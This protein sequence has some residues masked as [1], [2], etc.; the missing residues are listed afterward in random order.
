[1]GSVISFASG[2][3]GSSFSARN[4]SPCPAGVVE[5]VGDEIDLEVAE[6]GDLAHL[7]S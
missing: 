3:P 4:F 5:D 2:S 1:M 6:A 7:E